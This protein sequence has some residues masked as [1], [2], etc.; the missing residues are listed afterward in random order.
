[1]NAVSYSQS[2]N[3]SYINEN[4][5]PLQINYQQAPYA[6]N[7]K[8]KW[9]PRL[10]ILDSSEFVHHQFV[11][12]LQ[13]QEVIPFLRLGEAKMHFDYDEF[14]KANKLLD[15]IIRES[16]WSKAAPEA[17]Y[18]QGVIGYKSGKDPQPLRDIYHKLQTEYPHSS[19]ADRAFPY[20]SI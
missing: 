20:W 10:L 11:G 4:V 15:L 3:I 19:W 16:A 6:E 12:F 14:E 13:P 17:L 18:L 5:V 8:V 9:T 1:M 2:K 7:Y